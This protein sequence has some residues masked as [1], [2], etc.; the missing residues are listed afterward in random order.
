MTKLIYT[1]YK[2]SNTVNNKIYIG[3]HSTTNPNDEYFGSGNLIKTAILK[4]GKKSF[5]KSILFEYDNPNDAYLK[6]SQIVNQYFVKS[7][8]T[9]N[10]CVGGYGGKLG[11]KFSKKQKEQM[12]LSH[13]GNTH[14]IESRKKMSLNK[15]KGFNH[16]LFTGYYITPWGKFETSLKASTN[17]CSYSTIQ[18]W[19][20]NPNTIINKHSIGRSNYLQSLNESPLGKTVKDLGFHFLSLSLYN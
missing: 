16:H 10:L 17:N 1:V 11:F 20:K 4:Y 8:N 18:R 7:T 2:I 12:S 13:I 9:Y 3:V 15:Q 5:T 14:S 6:E 19:C